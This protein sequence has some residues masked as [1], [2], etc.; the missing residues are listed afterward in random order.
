[1]S[2]L[3]QRFG[4]AN[5]GGVEVLH[6]RQRAQHLALDASRRVADR[7]DDGAGARPDGHLL[8]RDQDRSIP[9][10]WS[11]VPRNGAGAATSSAATTSS[12][13]RSTA[14]ASC[15]IAPRTAAWT[16]CPG[17]CEEFKL[18]SDLDQQTRARRL[19]RALLPAG[20]RVLAARRRSACDAAAPQPLDALA[21]GSE[22]HRR[23]VDQRRVQLDP[24]PAQ[25]G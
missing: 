11:S 19:H 12:T 1:M 10:R 15:R 14:G 16:T 20:R 18:R 3:V 24:A 6:P 5:A 25:P 17:C 2:H 8:R 13:A 9:M 7:R 4:R 22:L 21:L 23:D